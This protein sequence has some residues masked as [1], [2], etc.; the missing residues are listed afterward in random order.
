MA[1]SRTCLASNLTDR[2]FRLVGWKKAVN[3]IDLNFRKAIKVPLVV[4]VF[5]FF[6]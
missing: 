1:S 5:F 6:G 3:I 2:V 4:V